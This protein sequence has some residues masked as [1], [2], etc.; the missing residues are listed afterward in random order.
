MSKSLSLTI[1]ISFVLSG[2]RV[3]ARADR[4]P[5]LLTTP[6]SSAKPEGLAVDRP[7]N[8]L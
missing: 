4:Y 6:P 2:R 7:V 3:I 5:S 8:S 1:D